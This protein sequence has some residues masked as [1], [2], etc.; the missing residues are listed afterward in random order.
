MKMPFYTQPRIRREILAFNQPFKK[1]G[2]PRV[3]T[4]ILL[5]LRKEGAATK[6][7]ILI[8]G[9]NRA[10]R[11][12]DSPFSFSKHPFRNDSSGY[13]SSMFSD[14]HAAG[15]ILWLPGMKRWVLGPRYEE[16]KKWL[17]KN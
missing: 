9:L 3:Y 4:R 5:Y 8:H 16:W 15:L 14:M 13:L 10:T 2:E 12:Y 17:R 6:K 7:E 1:N 11:L